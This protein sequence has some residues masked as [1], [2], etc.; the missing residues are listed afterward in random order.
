VIGLLGYPVVALALPHKNPKVNDFFDRQRNYCN[1]QVVSTNNVKSCFRHMAKGDIIAIVGD[2]DFFGKGERIEMQGH[3]CL[4]PPGPVRFALK[5]KAHLVP[6]FM[7][8]DKKYSYRLVFSNAISP[9]KESG[10]KTEKELLDECADVLGQYIWKYPE[11]WY[12]FGK[13]WVD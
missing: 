12:M 7:I 2:R 11:Q 13:F 4:L 5:G 8:R 6:V 1:V 3:G 10:L 9:F